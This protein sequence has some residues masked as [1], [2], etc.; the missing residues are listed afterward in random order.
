MRMRRVPNG[1]VF[2]SSFIDLSA[3][4]QD[5]TLVLAELSGIDSEDRLDAVSGMEAA[6]DAADEICHTIAQALREN[7]VTPFDREDIFTLA[8]AMRD[9]TH[10]LE[11]VGFAMASSAFDDLPVGALEM[12]AVI[13]NQADRTTRMAQRLRGQADQWEYVDQVIRMSYQAVRLQQ[14]MTGAV[15]S[16]K[17][18]LTYVSAA[19]RLGASFAGAARGFRDVGLAV[20]TIAVK[21]S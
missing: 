16:A 11:E 6:G 8:D 1:A 4:L 7:F 17:R 19:T 12:L 15:P 13:S 2:F 3:C 14:R 9:A 18:G 20:A 10:K 21:E 5:A